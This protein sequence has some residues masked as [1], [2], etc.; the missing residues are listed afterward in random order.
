M[1]NRVMTG[2]LVSDVE[3]GGTV[4]DLGRHG[5]MMML[6]RRRTCLIDDRG[7][8]VFD[9]WSW[10]MF[11]ATCCTDT[12]GVSGNELKQPCIVHRDKWEVAM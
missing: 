7:C 1:K 2:C 10:E 9:E 4:Q 11:L 8:V 12:A 6:D 3:G 5:D